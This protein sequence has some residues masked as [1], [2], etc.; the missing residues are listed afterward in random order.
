[1]F[2]IVFEDGRS[3]IGLLRKNGESA[4]KIVTDL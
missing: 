4:L 1:M 3:C 2:E